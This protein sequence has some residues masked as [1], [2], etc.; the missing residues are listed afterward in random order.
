MSQNI[1]GPLSGV[2]V[3]DLTTIVSGPVATMM[4]ADQGADVIKV[5]PLVGEQ[6]R[7]LGT[8]QPVGM[9]GIFL[10]CNRSKRSICV[11]LK[12]K[13]GLKILQELVKTADVFVQN[14]R[15]GAADRI[16]LGEVAVREIKKDIIYAS[17][18]GFGEKGPYCGQRVYDPVIQAL[19][20]LTDIQ[21]DP[22]TGLPKMIRTIIP[23]KTTSVT[24][25][26]AITAAL[27]YRERTGKG[28]HIRLAMLDTMIAFLWP[29]AMSVLSF[30]GNEG[31]PKHGSLGLDLVFKTKD[32]HITAG[33]I[34]DK[35][36]KGMCTVF[37]REDLISD[38]RFATAKARA[39]HRPERLKIMSD[40]ILKWSSNELLKRFQE[41]GVPCAPILTRREILDDPQ[42]IENQIFD[43]F[44]SEH[45]GK[46]RQPRPAARFNVSPSEVRSM[47]PLLGEDNKDILSELGYG[48]EEV[49]KLEQT[50]IIRSVKNEITEG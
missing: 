17:I 21:A 5:E 37:N 50:N 2:R 44:N 43:V 34:S 12:T 16:G 24:A 33:A 36:W 29:E 7:Q 30:V 48:S 14:F 38:D 42:V 18:S 22:D 47:A 41:E 49:A 31:D 19:S 20:G 9:T 3:I 23:D 26:Q 10:S 32:R 11:N 1:E 13:E 45:L 40:E 27:F 4:L 39:M 15:P 28:Q 8:P 25:A 35:E 46:I 6:L